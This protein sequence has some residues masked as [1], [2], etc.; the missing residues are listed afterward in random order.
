MCNHVTHRLIK[1]F[2][3]NVMAR[4]EQMEGDVE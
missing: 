4:G 3:V 2:E 1:M